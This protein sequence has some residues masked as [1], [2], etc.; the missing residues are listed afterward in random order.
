M[1]SLEMSQFMRQHR[2]D[3]RS[4]QARQQR[5]KKNDP[6]GASETRKIRIAMVAPARA[7]HYKQARWTL[8]PHFRISC[9]MRAFSG[10]S[11]SGVN[12]LNS[13][14]Y[15]TGKMARTIRLKPIHTAMRKTTSSNPSF[16]SAIKYRVTAV[17]QA[18]FSKPAWQDRER[19]CEGV[20]LL[21]P[22][23]FFD[24]NAR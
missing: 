13:R 21:K 24:N 20:I 17:S 15:P 22:K 12:L 10:A 7:I 6:L 16:P 9:S 8:N 23:L 2:L 14:S 18:E 19:T 5:I 1:V 11:S 4:V 3:F